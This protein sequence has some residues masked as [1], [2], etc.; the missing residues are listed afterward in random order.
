MLLTVSIGIFAIERNVPLTE[1][2]PDGKPQ[3]DPN[4]GKIPPTVGYDD[5]D[6]TLHLRTDSVL[7]GVH[8]AIKNVAGQVLQTNTIPVLSGHKSITLPEAVDEQKFSIEVQRDTHTF[9]G[10]F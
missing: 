7:T 9:S 1:I 3:E 6:K 5:E 8:L 10:I 4:G 2:P